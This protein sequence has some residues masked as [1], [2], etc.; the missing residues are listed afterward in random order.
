MEKKWMVWIIGIWMGLMIM[1]AQAKENRESMD[2]MPVPQMVKCTQTPFYLNNHFAIAIHG[3]EDQDLEMYATRILRRL[4]G[5]TGLFF[6][7]AYVRKSDQPDTPSMVIEFKRSG[8]TVLHEEESYL[9]TVTDQAITLKAE[10]SFGIMRGLETLVQ[11]LDADSSGYFFPGCWIQDKPRFPWRGL[12]IDVCRN[13]LPMDVILRNLDGMA[14]LKMNVLHLHLSEDQGFRIESK[15]FPKLH[16]LGSDGLYFSQSQIREIVRYAEA[17]GIRVVPEFDMPGH[18]TSW[19]VAY[20]E[21]ASAPGPY[22]ICR[23]W[24]VQDPVFNPASEKTY[25]FLEKFIREMATL[26]PDAYFHIGGD[27]NNGQH[28][29]ANAEIQQFMKKHNIPDN[30]ALQAYFNQRILKILT[31]CGKKMV[32]WDE[33][34]H[35]DMPTSIVVHSWRGPQYMMESAQKGYNGILSNGY[36]VD[37]IQ[38]AHFHY[39]N[40]PVPPKAELKPE[41]LARILGGEATMWS[42][43]V[44]PENVDSRIWPRTAAI[45]ER[46]WSSASV[47]DVDDMYR[48]LEV[49]EYQLEEV[50]LTHRKNYEM[51]LRRLS[52]DTDITAVK[53]LV[54]IIEPLKIYDRHQ[55][56]V[57]YTSYSP[58]TRAVDAARPE[59]LI[60]GHF[61]RLVDEF[62]KKP[63]PELAAQINPWLELWKSNHTAFIQTSRISPIL[64]EMDSMSSDLA[65]LATISQ[66]SLEAILSVRSMSQSWQENAKSV[67]QKAKPSRGQAELMVI[68]PMERLMEAVMIE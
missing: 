38:P 2:L 25:R 45:A 7:Q 44:T 17:R 19:L 66:E 6:P 1:A 31:Q 48:R 35:P 55:Q 30:H 64:R 36:Y 32:G 28:W 57:T 3:P 34:L 13:F 15:S 51:M 52:R 9:L 4:G 56:G 14:M 40:D 63:N 16:Q 54:D 42:E 11:L 67:F 41:E 68:V 24:G 29:S 58:L 39:L 22:T 10:T 20:P 33:I 53:T 61:S 49:I 60:A 62:I 27:E 50:G 43:L 46:F 37:L 21:L 47:C 18:A 23:R 12:M 8:K 65:S 26:F 59:S 5:K